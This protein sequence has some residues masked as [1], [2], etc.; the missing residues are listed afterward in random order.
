M[1]ASFESILL[2]TS[3]QVTTRLGTVPSLVGKLH[4]K[5]GKMQMK[6][7]IG[8]KGHILMGFTW[9]QDLL[10]ESRPMKSI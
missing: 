4:K 10:S 3:R 9:D 7:R 1:A 2:H 5:Y 8:P 6:E